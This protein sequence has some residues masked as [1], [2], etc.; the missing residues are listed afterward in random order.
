M[1]EQLRRE[2]FRILFPLGAVLAWIAVLPW[3]LFGT[4]FIRAWLGTYHALT[5][6]QGFLIAMVLGFLGTLLPRRTG[7]APFSTLELGIC[8]VGLVA[9]P[10]GLVTGRL[11]GAE[12]AYLVVLVT[13]I[14]FAV[15]RVPGGKRP[16]HPSFVWM[17]V[18]LLAGMVGS[19]LIIVSAL[20]HGSLLAAG[21]ALVEEGLLLSLVLAVAPMLASVITQDHALPD[22]SAS[23]YRRQRNL[24]LVAGALLLGSF[25]VQFMLSERA[26]MLLRGTVVAAEVLWACRI[27]RPPSVPGLHRWLFWL[28]LIFVPLG[29]L[30][31][32]ARPALRVPF[33]H[34][35]FIGG[36]SML[37]FAVS[38]HV[39][40]MHTG[41]E[42]LARRWP[43]PV[44]AAGLLVLLATGAR[45][46]A[47]QFPEHYFGALAI[48]SSLWLAGALVWGSFVISLVA[49]AP[50]GHTSI[51]LPG[52]PS[53]DPSP[54][55]DRGGHGSVS[56]GQGIE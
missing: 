50:S 41:R 24:H 31:A 11:V 3:M 7:C 49:R 14:Q 25:A 33:L 8:V 56:S 54:L 53:T 35:T 4:G 20:G 43:W 10:I 44:A 1:N 17:P 21:R 48:A 12:L 40:F 18:G 19:V 46:S 51:S 23:S 2:P 30:C 42:D 13:L 52:S 36:F 5:M 32:G 39:V 55:M 34:L 26:G 16:P 28:A 9:V 27:D 37:V 38:F 22:P 29:L 6:T 45:V 15:R 47:E